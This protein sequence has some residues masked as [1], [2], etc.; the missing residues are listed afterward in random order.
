MYL[1]VPLVGIAALYFAGQKAGWISAQDPGTDR[2]REIA[3]DMVA[4]ERREVRE[5]KPSFPLA[6]P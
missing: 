6:S 3:R 1:L 5:Q 4:A 2:M